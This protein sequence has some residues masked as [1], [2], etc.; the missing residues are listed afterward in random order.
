[1]FRG[2]KLKY[3]QVDQYIKKGIDRNIDISKHS[4]VFSLVDRDFGH[5]RNNVTMKMKFS[6]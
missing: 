5:V 4:A 6:E 2:V 1:M 3:K